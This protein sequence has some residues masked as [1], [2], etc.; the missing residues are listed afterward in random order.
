MCIR[1]SRYTQGG[2]PDTS[3]SLT[4][5]ETNGALFYNVTPGQV[6]V[7]AEHPTCKQ[8]PFPVKFDGVTY[9][10]ALTTEP[11][12]SFSF[13]RIFLGPANRS[14]AGTDAAAADASHDADTDS[15]VDAG[16]D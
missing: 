10:G 8:L 11:G 13:I 1:D 15:S 4:A 9:T 5:G 2:V 16:T 7:T 6:T 14:D 3:S 12:A